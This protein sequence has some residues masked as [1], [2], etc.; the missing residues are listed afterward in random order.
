MIPERR[1][2]LLLSGFM[3]TGKSTVGRALALRL[4]HPFADLDTIIEEAAGQAI[5]DIFAAEGEEGF[6]ERE[7]DALAQLLAETAPAPRV[8][9]LGGGA[10]LDDTSR[11]HALAQAFVITLTAAPA[12]ILARSEGGSRP[13]LAAPGPS[14]TPLDRIDQLLKRRAATYAQTHLS[15]STEGRSVAAVV[16]DVVAHWRPAPAG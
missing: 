11:R 5:A 6:R 16:D 1:P 3:G 9:A 15:L 10:L 14:E 4:G 13:L 2:T 12:T 8:V 7:R